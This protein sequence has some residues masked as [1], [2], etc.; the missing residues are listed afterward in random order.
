MGDLIKSLF[1]EDKTKSGLKVNNKQKKYISL[2][3]LVAF[4]GVFAIY[5]GNFT[6]GNKQ[7]PLLTNIDIN[8]GNSPLDKMSELAAAEK[9][10]AEK[11]ENILC[12]SLG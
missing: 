11:L 10:M 5:L 2:L 4:L 12:Q 8:S 3:V 1:P 6:G 7:E 9:Q